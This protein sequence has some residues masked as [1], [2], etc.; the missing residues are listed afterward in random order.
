MDTLLLSLLILLVVALMVALYLQLRRPQGSADLSTP[1]QNLTQAIQTVNAR[2]AVLEERLSHMQQNHDQA[3]QDI[4]ELKTGVTKASTDASNLIEATRTIQTQ[5]T[6]ARENLVELQTQAKTRQEMES[7]TAESIRRLE[8]VIAGT[9][10][11]GAA[12][13]NILEFVFAKLPPDWQVRNFKVGNKTVEFGLRLPNSLVLPI[14]S[15]WPAT[16]LLE[17]F[18]SCDDPNEQQRLK[19]QIQR[20]VLS[21]AGEVRKYLDPNLTVSFGVAA[22]PDAVY[23][24]CSGIQTE[25][26]QMNVVL[27][28]YNMFLPSLLLVFQ[29]VLKTSQDID[30]E[31]LDACLQT[32]QDSVKALQ[33][34]LEGRFSRALTMLN[35][36]RN[37]MSLHLSK[38]SSGLTSLQISAGKSTPPAPLAE[39]RSIAEQSLQD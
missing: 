18:T 16:D 3:G 5:L 37:D 23:D 35:N 38:V 12:G 27:V 36:S 26:F 2:T 20:E 15:K 7:R 19:S 17:Q 4:Q 31:K 24:L 22:I 29:T 34:E 13:E 11:K 10:A 9:Q 30:L 25:V 33:E 32:A 28:G 39:P 8:T 21:K 6:Q 1:F 14:D